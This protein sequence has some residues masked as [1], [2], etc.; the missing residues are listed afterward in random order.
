MGDRK[1]P[2]VVWSMIPMVLAIGLTGLYRVTH[3]PSFEAHRRIDVVRLVIIGAYAGVVMVTLARTFMGR[4]NREQPR[5]IL[6]PLAMVGILVIGLIPK[7]LE[8]YRAVDIVQL[9]GSG[10]CFG[11]ALGLVVV[12]IRLRASRTDDAVR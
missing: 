7:D 2:S 6:G 3:S 11:V 12:M 10:A 4:R 8:L 9:A 1:P 5:R